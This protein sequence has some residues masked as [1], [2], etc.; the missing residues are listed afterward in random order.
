MHELQQHP[1]IL[2]LGW[3]VF[4]V[5]LEQISRRFDRVHRGRAYTVRMGRNLGLGLLNKFLI[6]LITVPI[7]LFGVH[8]SLWVRPPWMQGI[9]ATIVDVMILDLASYWFHLIAHKWKPLWHFHEVH[10]L[11][12]DIDASTGLR[13]HPFEIVLV[14]LFRLP[15][16]ILLGVPLSSVIA[17]EVVLGLVGTFHHGNFHLPRWAERIFDWV[18][19]SPT[20]HY[21]HHHAIIEDTDS[22]Y[23]FIFNWWDRLFGSFNPKVR[24]ADWQMGLEYSPDR[25]LSELLIYPFTGRDWKDEAVASGSFVPDTMPAS[26]PTA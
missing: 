5:A 4:L 24:P 11:D 3:F 10:H 17:F 14:N 1:L 19:I 13:I 26:K 8:N 16:L 7:V 15:V 2:I 25:S 20:Q 12:Q 22:A 21:C 23:G 18:V 6:P 9:I